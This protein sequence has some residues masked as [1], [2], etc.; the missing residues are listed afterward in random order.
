MPRFLVGLLCWLIPIITLAPQAKATTESHT[1]PVVVGKNSLTQAKFHELLRTN[2]FRLKP[3]ALG[4][5]LAKLGFQPQLSQLNLTQ[6]TTQTEL[7][8]IAERAIHL[9]TLLDAVALAQTNQLSSHDINQAFTAYRGGNYPVLERVITR[10]HAQLATQTRSNTANTSPFPIAV[11]SPTKTVAALTEHDNAF[12]RQT[13]WASGFSITILILFSIW[14]LI[15]N[16][17]LKNQSQIPKL[18]KQ[19]QTM[20]EHDERQQQRIAKLEA[21]IS[22]LLTENRQHLN[23][24]ETHRNN[25]II[26]RS[27]TPQTE[28]EVLPLHNKLGS[29]ISDCKNNVDHH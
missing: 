3:D 24:L 5:T 1:F 7:E 23:A 27:A 19:I 2:S 20:L 18:R 8:E 17:A 11:G 21:K 12:L 15:N 25:T 4:S 9:D 29:L 14:L 6:H 13:V 16:A 26:T 10:W 22:D 28:S